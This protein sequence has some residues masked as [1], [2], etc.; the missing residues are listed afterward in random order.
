MRSNLLIELASVKYC[1]RVFVKK[2]SCFLTFLKL[3][4]LEEKLERKCYD[5]CLSRL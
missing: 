3:N 5:K 4:C 1:F 2:P